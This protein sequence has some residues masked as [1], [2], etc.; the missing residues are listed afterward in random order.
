[1]PTFETPRP[2]SATVDMATGHLHITASDRPDTAVDVRP[3]DPAD[4]GDVAAADQTV[5]ELSGD[6]LVVRTPRNRLRS[7]FGRPPSVEITVGL[8]TASRV[9]V[10][11]A[12]EVRGDGRLGE[13]RVE[14]AA[15]AVRLAETGRLHVRTSAGDVS[16]ARSDGHTEITTASGKVRVGAVDGS[17]V[18]KSSN[19]DITVG[20]V[21][22]EVRLTTANGDIVVDRALATVAAKT[23]FGSVRVGEVARGAVVLETG[24]GEVEVGVRAG[25]AAWLDVK[26]GMGS[27]RSLLDAADEPAAADDTVEVRARTGYGDIVIRRA[28]P[29]T[30]PA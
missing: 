20:E 12:G 22:G 17:A 25:T 5:V 11:A 3:T 2:I 19:G 4:D 6:R 28:E 24:F 8:P 7:L 10:S 15:G 9:E 26:S 18:V 27:V 21:S 14:T 23:A 16:V 29:A 1:M 30:G 13:T